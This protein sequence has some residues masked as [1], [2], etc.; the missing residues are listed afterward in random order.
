MPTA[1]QVIDF[2][3]GLRQ[4]RAELQL[5]QEERMMHLEH[6]VIPNTNDEIMVSEKEEV[7]CIGKITFVQGGTRVE[8]RKKGIKA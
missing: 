7:E 5:T 3:T 2:V 8:R 4:T 6:E 1:E